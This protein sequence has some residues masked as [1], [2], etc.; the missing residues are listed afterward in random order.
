MVE[1]ALDIKACVATRAD[2]GSE[3]LLTVFRRGAVTAGATR[4]GD[5]SIL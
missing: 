4:E 1:G 5:K 3:P 2:T